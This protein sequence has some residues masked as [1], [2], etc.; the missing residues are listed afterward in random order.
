[1]AIVDTFGEKAGPLPVW[2]W[3]LGAAALLAWWSHRRS[4]QPVPTLPV[5]TNPDFATGETGRGLNSWGGRYWPVAVYQVPPYV[6]GGHSFR[7]GG[8]Y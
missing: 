3:A 4:R 7:N 1:M 8:G 6:F 2:A 5:I